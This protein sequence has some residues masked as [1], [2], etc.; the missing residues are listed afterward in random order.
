[1]RIK[2]FSC[3]AMS[4]YEI[5]CDPISQHILFIYMLYIIYIIRKL[6][7][8]GQTYFTVKFELRYLAAASA[9]VTLL[10]LCRAIDRHMLVAGDDE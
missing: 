10:H 9:V 6:Y 4:K 3:Q 1:M 2:L 5:D 8:V 7:N